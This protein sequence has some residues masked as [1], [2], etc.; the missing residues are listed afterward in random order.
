MKSIR[1]FNKVIIG[2]FVGMMLAIIGMNSSFFYQKNYL[3]QAQTTSFPATITSTNI[4]N[5][6]AKIYDS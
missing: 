1:S 6:S 4:I 2:L 3:A 5:R